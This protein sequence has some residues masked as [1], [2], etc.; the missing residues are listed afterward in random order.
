MGT[1]DEQGSCSR[2]VSGGHHD[3]EMA[4]RGYRPLGPPRRQTWAHWRTIGPS[5]ETSSATRQGH[6]LPAS[7]TSLTEVPGSVV[8]SVPRSFW[9]AWFAVTAG[10]WVTSDVAALVLGYVDLHPQWQLDLLAFAAPLIAASQ[11]W[12]LR[13]RIPLSAWWIVPVLVAWGAYFP[14]RLSGI[15]REGIM[16]FALATFP[17][18][19]LQSPAGAL[20]A[21]AVAG[22][23]LGGIF[24]GISGV[25][26]WRSLRPHTRRASLWIVTSTVAYAA[27]GGTGW[28]VTRLLGTAIEGRVASAVVTAILVGAVTAGGICWHLHR[29]AGT[30]GPEAPPT[31]LRVVQVGW[32]F[33]V[34]WTTLVAIGWWCGFLLTWVLIAVHM[35]RPTSWLAGGPLGGLVIFAL[36]WPLLRRRVPRLSDWALG[37]VA[38]WTLAWLIIPVLSDFTRPVVG[39]WLF[40]GRSDL[41][42]RMSIATWMGT[43]G[44]AAG[45]AVAGWTQARAL[46]LGRGWIVVSASAWIVGLAVPWASMPPLEGWQTFLLVIPAS[47]AVV[48]LLTGGMLWWIGRQAAATGEAGAPVP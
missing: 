22:A 9:W 3:L 21:N 7:T 37:L 19:F 43:V 11:W 6:V 27:G 23:V 28:A 25:G 1:H 5:M 4:G 46:S 38:G 18:A 34:G 2:V 24:G 41:P 16:A 47:G 30:A 14:L 8:S 44:G 10:G 26:Q 15:V 45:G 32:R 40:P 31:K 36:Q 20:L 13:R 29:P 17:L 12:V 48:G 42:I 39:I 33:L 35:G